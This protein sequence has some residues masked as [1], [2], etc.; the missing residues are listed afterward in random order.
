[1]PI[2]PPAIPPLLAQMLNMPSEDKEQ[3]EALLYQD[4]AEIETAIDTLEGLAMELRARA[5][6][7]RAIIQKAR[8]SGKEWS[9]GDVLANLSKS[10]PPIQQKAQQ[11]H[12][13]AF[14]AYQTLRGINVNR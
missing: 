11:A 1:M 2:L 10:F 9:A 4:L 14:G 12:A 13:I 5:R 7:E 6:Q 3:R 8:D